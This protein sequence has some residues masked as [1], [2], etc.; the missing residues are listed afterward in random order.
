MRCP[1]RPPTPTATLTTFFVKLNN[2]F[3][4]NFG[5]LGAAANDGMLAFWGQRR[6]KGCWRFGGMGED[7]M[8]GDRGVLIFE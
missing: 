6:T 5:V 8:E 4:I 2:Y 3:L 7:P 1:P